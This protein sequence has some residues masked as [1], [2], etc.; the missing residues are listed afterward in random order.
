MYFEGS[1][2]QE[3]EREAKAEYFNSEFESLIEKGVEF[4]E[5]RRLAKEHVDNIFSR[6]GLLNNDI[7]Y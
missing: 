6:I 2:E 1:L 3:A 5:A 4:H 7:I